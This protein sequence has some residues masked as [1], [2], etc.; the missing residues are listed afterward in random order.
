MAGE[1][2]LGEVRLFGF[3]YAPRGWSTAQG[4]ILGVAQNSALYSLYG[5]T[6]GGNGTNTFGLP[7]L[8]GRIPIGQGQGPGLPSIQM[9]TI[10]G[11]P[12]TALTLANLP[13]H[14]HSFTGTLNA[15]QGKASTQAPDAGS[16]LARAN[17]EN[18]TDNPFIYVPAGTSGT[19]VG[20]GGVSGTTA[21]AGSS[22]PFSTLP[23]VLG[24]NYSVAL[25]GIFPS[26]N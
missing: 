4:Q 7:D 22:Q 12:Q 19:Q 15:V 11:T 10:T 20:L 13:T 23:P 2:F 21:P 18:G 24:L 8:R 5:T 6:Y 9:G 3:S 25:A 1:P 16:L 26:R 17:D 14:N